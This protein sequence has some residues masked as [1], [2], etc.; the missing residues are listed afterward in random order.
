ME[1]N[2]KPK[3]P[4]PPAPPIQPRPNMSAPLPPPQRP[5]GK[6][7]VKALKIITAVLCLA[8]IAS[9]VALYSVWNTSNRV[10][11]EKEE[12]ITEKDRVTEDLERLK[13]D[14]ADLR[15]NNDSLN[16]RLDQERKK[17]DMLLTK[18]K[19]TDA[20]NRAKLREYEQEISNLKTLLNGYVKQIDELSAENKEL[21]AENEKVKSEAS[22]SKQKVEE[23][24]QEAGMLKSMVEKGSEI[25]VRD[26]SAIALNN[27]DKTVSRARQT[28]QIRACLTLVENNIAKMGLKSVYLR[29]KAP[30]GSLLTQSGNNLF[31]PADG[32]AQMI[33]SAMRDVEYN[34]QDLE[35]CVFYKDTDFISGTYNIEIYL[36][37][38]IV[39]STQLVLK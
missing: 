26:L 35:V 19:K 5:S 1:D 34:G 2:I 10:K 14:Y 7:G 3:F 23:L 28:A 15:S 27:R 38:S 16:S 9:L 4:A 24:S 22:Q 31:D 36:D 11:A 21:R 20:S 39:G 17:I 18:I 12:V 25:K 29:V 8:L 6:G 32:G 33:Y 30:D 13:V 37:G